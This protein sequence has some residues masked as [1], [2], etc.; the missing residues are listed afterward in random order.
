MISIAEAIDAVMSRVRPTGTER[1]PL[2]E[3]AGR[4]L[5]AELAVREDVPGFDNSAMDGYAVRAADVASVPVELPVRGES[6]AGG[7]A[8]GALE[9]GAAMRIFTGAPLPPG[10][11]AIV[12]QEDTDRD[13]DAVVIRESSAVG[14]HVRRRA[15]V[16]AEG[17][18]LMA[19]GARIEAGEIGV[20]ASQGYAFLPVAR[21]PRVAILSTGDELRELGEAPR[22]G[23]LVDSN[24]HA[25][26]AAVRDAGGLPELL[27]LGADDADTLTACVRDAAR[28][29]DV[30]LSTGGVSVGEYDLVHDAFRAAGVEEVFW[31]IRVKPGKPVRFGVRDD[32]L[33]LGLPGNP[34]SALVTFE[35]F[36]RPALRAMQG[37]PRPFRPSGA[38]R[39]A[40]PLRSP[41][42]RDELARARLDADGRAHPH[43]T[44]GSADLTSLVGLDVLLHLPEGASFEAGDEVRGLDMR[45]RD[46]AASHPFA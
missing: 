14:K 23:S 20:L 39:L 41:R 25:L 4:I 9:A 37:D 29:S 44:Q 30:L 1:V 3:A 46:G 16:L 13:G 12:I 34:V 33:V 28:R 18:P 21:R 7:P 8:P 35:L 32:T 26:A 38:F 10:A 2:H 15:E 17:A 40:S 45:R 24:A 43:R 11:D 5:A 42:G 22:P 27:P 36:V 31:K 6:R 19:P